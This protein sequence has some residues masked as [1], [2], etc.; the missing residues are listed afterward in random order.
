[1]IVVAL[2][3]LEKT[4]EKSVPLVGVYDD[5]ETIHAQKNVRRKE[6]DALVPV[7]ERVIHEERLEQRGRHTR[8]VRIVPGLGAK[9]GALQESDVPDATRSTEDLNQ[10]LVN[11]EDFVNGQEENGVI[12]Q[13]AALGVRSR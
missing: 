1:M 3:A 5:L 6:A 2:S 13:G 12:R 4:N 9:E 8:E 10:T 11:G 7:D